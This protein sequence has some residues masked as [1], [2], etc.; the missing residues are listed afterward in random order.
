MPDSAGIQKM[1]ALNDVYEQAICSMN[2][3]IYLF[4]SLFIYLFTYLF[5]D[6]HARHC[7]D[8]KNIQE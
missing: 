1:I 7:R 6:K 3:F 8:T 4:I 2:L 5:S